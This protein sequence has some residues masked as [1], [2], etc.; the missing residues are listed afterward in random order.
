MLLV[1]LGVA[2]AQ[3]HSRYTRSEPADGAQVESAPFVLKSWYSQEL[4]LRSKVSVVSADGTQVDLGDGRVDQEDPDR[5]VMVVSLPA[6]PEG[7][8]RVRWL[9]WSAEDGH[10]AE[11]EFTFIVGAAAGWSPPSTPGPQQEE[12]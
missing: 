4:M 3:A 10:D 9:A 5:K 8:Y 2:P 12:S 11:G 6:L 7:T 1:L